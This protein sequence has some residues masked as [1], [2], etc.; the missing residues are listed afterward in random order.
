MRARLLEEV[1]AAEEEEE[2][3]EE[4]EEEAVMMLAIDFGVT[5]TVPR[6]HIRTIPPE[7]RGVPPQVGVV[8]R[9]VGVVGWVVGVAG[10]RG[11]KAHQDTS[12]IPSLSCACRMCLVPSLSCARC[13][14]DSL[15][16]LVVSADLAG[17]VTGMNATPILL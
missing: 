4:K 11:M 1:A 8:Q 9:V 13:S 7:C 6:P 16:R 5:L 3:E 12:L 14:V 17:H 15:G 2:E 10:G